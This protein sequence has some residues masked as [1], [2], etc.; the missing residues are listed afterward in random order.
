MTVTIYSTSTCPWCTKAEEFL[1]SLNVHFEVKDI[2]GDKES[3]MFLVK[4]TQQMGVPVIQIGEKFIVGY[5]PDEIKAVLEEAKI[6]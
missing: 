3:A 4:K 2:S 6:I 5:K 1:S